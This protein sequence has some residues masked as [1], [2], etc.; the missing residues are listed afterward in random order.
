[1]DGLTAVA[2]SP[3]DCLSKGSSLTTQSN[4]QDSDASINSS[5]LANLNETFSISA[6]V[7]LFHG[8]QKKTLK[9]P[10]KEIKKAER[11]KK[12]YFKSK[13]EDK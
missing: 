2:T 11:I 7:I 12:E 1:M 4:A 3:W 9:T 8:I 5:I 13:E 6:V 10:L